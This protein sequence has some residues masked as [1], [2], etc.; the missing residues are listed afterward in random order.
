MSNNELL[1][2][3]RPFL[4]DGART[5]LLMQRIRKL[6][7]EA[8]VRELLDEIDTHGVDERTLRFLEDTAMHVED[9]SPPTEKSPLKET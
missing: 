6:D 9:L 4:S 1:N 8:F 2:L 5:I 7:P 3:T